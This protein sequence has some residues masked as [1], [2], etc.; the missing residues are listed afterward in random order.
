MGGSNELGETLRRLRRERRLSG[1]EVAASVGVTQGT[2][3]KIEHGRI[4]PDLDFLSKFSHTLRLRQDE[5]SRLMHLAGVMPAGITPERAL[6][7]LPVD[8]L[9]VDWSERRQVTLAMTEARSSHIRVFNPLLVPGLLQ[10]E[11]YASHVI[12]AS[13]VHGEKRI[14]QA[15]R[16]RLRRQHILAAPGKR[17]TFIIT[18]SGLLSRI[19]PTDVLLEQLNRVR[20]FAS[21]SRID[22]GMIPSGA[23]LSVTP[24]PAF[25]LFD[26]RVYIELPHGDLWLLSRSNACQIYRSIFEELSRIALRRGELITKLDRLMHELR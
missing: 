18:E 25:Y 7:Y 13:G 23:A 20:Q 6:Q 10:T 8:F 1:T 26:R 3:S 22:I 24:P 16:A 14:K 2:I 11:R 5:A 4:V 9:Q 12:E 21:S 17:A 19:A 15:V